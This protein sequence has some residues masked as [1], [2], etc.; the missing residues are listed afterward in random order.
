LRAILD[1]MRW[2]AAIE[3]TI[4]IV[5]L[6]ELCKVRPWSKLLLLLLR[7][8]HWWP[9]ESRLLRGLAIHLPDWLFRGG[10]RGDV[11]WTNRYLGDWPLEDLVC[12]FRF[13]SARWAEIQS[14]W[15]IAMLTSSL[16][17]S[18]LTRFS[19]SLSLVFRPQRKW[20]RFLASVFAW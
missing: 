18:V 19:R 3:T 11:F 15:V 17:V 12:I 1:E 9:V 16:K 14:S 5:S 13:F 7:L 20:S 6:V 2:A 4:V 8:R 10:A